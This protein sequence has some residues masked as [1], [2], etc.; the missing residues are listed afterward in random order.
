MELWTQRLKLAISIRGIC[1]LYSGQKTVCASMSPFICQCLSFTCNGKKIN[2]RVLMCSFTVSRNKVMS[3]YLYSDSGEAVTAGFLWSE[4][5][6]KL[7]KMRKIVAD[8]HI[9]NKVEITVMCWQ[10]KFCR[11]IIWSL[12]L[13]C[14]SCSLISNFWTCL[15]IFKCW[16]R[17]H[18]ASGQSLVQWGMKSILYVLFLVTLLTLQFNTDG[19]TRWQYG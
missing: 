12:N 16:L 19:I 9:Q 13:V 5:L 1:E 6:I 17:L 7:C 10:D 3:W 14:A 18:F 11:Q 15:H 2:S 4:M 8:T